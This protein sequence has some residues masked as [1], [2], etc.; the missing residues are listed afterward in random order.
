MGIKFANSLSM[1]FKPVQILL[2]TVSL[3][4]IVI[5][6]SIHRRSVSPG[7]KS[8]MLLLISFILWSFAYSIELSASSLHTKI[9]WAKIKYIGV[10][11]IPLF[12]FIFSFH[13]TKRKTFLK[14]KHLL[15]IS[16]IPIATIILTWTNEWHGLIWSSH[17]LR[18]TDQLLI[19]DSVYGP[20]FIFYILY[21]YIMLSSS[22]LQIL[23]NIFHTSH[24]YKGQLASVLTGIFAPW[25]GN[26]LYLTRLNPIPYLDLT[27]FGFIITGIYLGFGLLRFQLFKVVPL[28]HDMVIENMSDAIIILDLHNNIVDVNLSG[29]RL[30]GCSSSKI[31][32]QPIKDALSNLFENMEIDHLEGEVKEVKKD[33]NCYELRLIPVFEK[34]KGLRGKILIFHDIT[35]RKKAEEALQKSHIELEKRVIERTEELT[36]TNEKLKQEIAERKQLEESLKESLALIG[37]AKREWESTVDSFP[38]I[39]CIFDHNGKVLRTNR[40]VED[41]NLCKVSDVKGKELHELIHPNCTDPDCYLKAFWA[42]AWQMAVQGKT[43]EEEADDKILNRILNIQVQP[44]KS[45]KYNIGEEVENCSVLIINDITEKKRTEKEISALEEQLRHA[46]KMEAIGRLTGGIAHDFNNLLTPIVGYSQ[47]ALQTL[48]PSDPLYEYLFEIKRASER[49]SNL[50]K[51]LMTFSRKKPQTPQTVDI[52]TILLDMNKMI[53][54]LIG[55]DIEL[56]IIPSQEKASVKLD[57]GLFEQIIVNLVVN[58]KDAMPNGGKLI[59]QTSRINLDN[60]YKIKHSVIKKG[61]Y[62]M[63]SV[64]DTGIGMTEEIKSHL[65]EP[66]FTTKSPGK[67]TGLGLSTVYGIVKQF[68]GDIEVESEAGVGTTFKIYFLYDEKEA[69]PLP[70]RDE[71]GYLP[72][73]NESI[74]LVEDEP[75]VRRF[76]SR[77]LRGQG[78]NVIEASNGI[79]ALNLLDRYKSDMIITDIVMPQMSGIELIDRVRPLLP[80]IKILFISGY[81]DYMTIQHN[82]LKPEIGFLEKPFSPSTLVRKV[83][84]VLDW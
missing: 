78:Y 11:S 70:L 56:I 67:G 79:E 39:I 43:H 76:A 2:N 57:P 84:E 8:F 77:I 61:Q 52:N 6:I 54:R 35:E 41:W 4:L 16:T 34:N 3:V 20:W 51:Q 15:L 49:A 65:F 48:L 19:R 9:L 31:I 23:R 63:V 37:R 45:K 38:Q 29:K 7:K 73:G 33:G 69:V 32:G 17:S 59:I 1:I 81:I 82:L 27:P 72:K 5:L 60:P 75:L 42:N 47:L 83:R 50:I 53:R 46:Q 62:V 66:F 36:K 21:S 30:F 24:I 68:N 64:S 28:A 10:I 55:E 74:L 12:W 26:M 14:T 13:Y 80:A 40:A 18:L 22:T 44:I 71:I 25:V 58:S